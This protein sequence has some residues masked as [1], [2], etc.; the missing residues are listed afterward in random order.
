MLPA[1]I[2]LFPLADVVLFPTVFLPLH[3]FEPRY[4]D[5]VRDA[6]ASDRI[7][8]MALLKPGYEPEYHAR[9]PIYDVGCAGLIT[10]HERLAD[11]CYNIVLRGLARFRVHREDHSRPYRLAHVES[12]AEPLADSDRAALHE[13]RRRLETLLVPLVEGGE[14]Q[15]PPNLPDDHLV[16]ALA[17]YLDLEAVERQALLEHDGL[18]SRC[19]SLIDL[20]EM[21]LLA[22]RAG[23]GTPAAKH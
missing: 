16:N 3:I 8:G 13:E 11:G 14:S 5:M 2:P 15:V 23:F 21:K 9:P 17:Q 4:R 1:T 19:R 12:L 18:L 6:L 22:G 7:I 20:I 10:H